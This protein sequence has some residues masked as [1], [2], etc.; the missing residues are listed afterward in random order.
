TLIALAYV[1]RIRWT[2]HR[3]KAL[4]AAF[5]DVAS[6][7]ESGNPDSL[8]AVAQEHSDVEAVRDLALLAAADIHLDAFRRGVKP[9]AQPDEKNHYNKEDILS[10]EEREAHLAKAKELYTQ[11]LQNVKDNPAALSRA[12]SA[13]AGLV[14]VAIGYRD[15]DEARRLLDEQI[16]LAE[17]RGAQFA[18]QQARRR[19]AQL[20]ELQ[21]LPPIFPQERIAVTRPPEAVSPVFPAEGATAAGDEAPPAA[22]P[23]TFDLPGKEGAKP[24]AEQEESPPP[25]RRPSLLR[26]KRARKARRLPPTPSLSRPPSPSRSRAARPRAN[27][28]LP[29]AK[30]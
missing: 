29:C 30:G 23:E 8:L 15:W 3:L 17:S 5:L 11:V 1:V 22:Q 24:A 19:L 16:A 4:D 2:Q 9:G 10:E 13:Y 14:S 26:K 27:P 20:D 6:A 18:A 25:S 12:M 7:R 28:S 21:Q